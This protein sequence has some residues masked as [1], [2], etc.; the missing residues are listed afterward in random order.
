MF[1]RLASRQC[2]YDVKLGCK[3]VFFAAVALLTREMFW[4]NTGHARQ[5]QKLAA[6]YFAVPC[7]E[8]PFWPSEAT[9]IPR[10]SKKYGRATSQQTTFFRFQPIGSLRGR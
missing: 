9:A 7:L 4:L 10:A 3:D 5:R 8:V 2:A 1:S 6:Q